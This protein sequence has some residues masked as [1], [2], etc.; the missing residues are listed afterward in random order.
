MRSRGARLPS[1]ACWRQRLTQ[2]D[3]RSRQSAAEALQ[4][5][6]IL[7]TEHDPYKAV[8]PPLTTLPYYL[9]YYSSVSLRLY[10]SPWASRRGRD[11]PGQGV[12]VHIGGGIAA[13][14][15][16]QRPGR[17]TGSN[18]LVKRLPFSASPPGVSGLSGCTLIIVDTF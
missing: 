6:P 9:D 2:C 13:G 11:G 8:T 14:G 12:Y 17:P 18:A 16:P 4:G 1:L 7:R 15:C 5:V 3:R 10:P